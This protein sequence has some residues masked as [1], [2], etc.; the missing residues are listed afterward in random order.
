M[1]LTLGAL[2]VGGAN[3]VAWLLAPFGDE[4]EAV[5]AFLLIAPALAAGL[6]A[7]RWVAIS[8]ALAWVPTYLRLDAESERDA[9]AA[10]PGES[11]VAAE[12]V[13]TAVLFVAVFIALGVGLG[14]GLSRLFATE[15]R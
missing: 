8:L 14:K 7:Q 15:Q 3:V 9:G 11:V 13:L 10:H 12:D 5:V 1:R 2:L 4:D 6:V